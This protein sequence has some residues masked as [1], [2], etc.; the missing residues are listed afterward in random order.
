MYQFGGEGPNEDVKVFLRVVHVRL[1]RNRQRAACVQCNEQNA[2][3]ERNARELTVLFAASCACCAVMAAAATCKGRAHK[4]GQQLR[5][6]ASFIGGFVRSAFL[7][8][9][10]YVVATTRP[11]TVTSSDT[12]AELPSQTLNLL[13]R[14][15]TEIT[16]SRD[17]QLIRST[18][19]SLLH[20]IRFG[21][22][23]RKVAACSRCVQF[24]CA[25]SDCVARAAQREFA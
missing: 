3:N 24:D 1:A 2:Q 11:V 9:S 7:L 23:C 13:G 4:S 16:N 5:L 15:C 20:L 21:F 8:R 25:N 12:D 18:D 17:A 14:V 22:M 6:S 10:S 19:T